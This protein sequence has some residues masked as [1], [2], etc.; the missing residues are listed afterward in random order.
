[1]RT[2]RGT[3]IDRGLVW[4]RPGWRSDRMVGLV[5]YV[6]GTVTMI[7]AGVALLIAGPQG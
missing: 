1:M 5:V 2:R 7:I 3:G 4:D 6:A